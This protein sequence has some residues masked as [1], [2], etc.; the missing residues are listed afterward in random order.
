MSLACALSLRFATIASKPIS[1]SDD[2]RTR[3]ALIQPLWPVV[4]Y[5][6]NISLNRTRGACQSDL[7]GRNGVGARLGLVS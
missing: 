4:T 3:T 1:R 2:W 5:C 6:S 7:N